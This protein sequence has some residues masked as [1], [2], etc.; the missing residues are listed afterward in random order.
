MALSLFINYG[1]FGFALLMFMFLSFTKSEYAFFV[2]L[3]IVLMNFSLTHVS[4]VLYRFLFYP[5]IHPF[6]YLI[7]RFGAITSQSLNQRSILMLS[8]TENSSNILTVIQFLDVKA[9]SFQRR[10]SS[11]A[12]VFQAEHS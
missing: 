8:G 2:F 12:G 9:R 4:Y 6:E 5:I 7:V 3:S 11:Q 10:H 1:F